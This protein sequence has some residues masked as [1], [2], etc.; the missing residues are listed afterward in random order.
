MNG[1]ISLE[2]EARDLLRQVLTEK[3]IV[4]QEL[5]KQIYEYQLEIGRLAQKGEEKQRKA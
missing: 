4:I 3:D 2:K 1:V 5:T